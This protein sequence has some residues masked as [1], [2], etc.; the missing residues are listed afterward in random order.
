MV[1]PTFVFSVVILT[2]AILAFGTTQ[3]YLR[4]SAA[5]PGTPCAVKNCTPPGGIRTGDGRAPGGRAT[6]GASPGSARASWSPAVTGPGRPAHGT[7]QIVY[8]TIRT[9]PTGFVGLLSLT[10]GAGSPTRHWK[11]SVSYPDVRINWMADATWRTYGDGTVTIEPLSHEPELGP[12]ATLQ[13]TFSAIGKPAAPASCRLNGARC[14]V[15]SE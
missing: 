8:R 5:G 13:I 2:M 10:F 14:Q 6:G 11:L 3:T 1:T 7:A 12:G 9:L 15:L 4:F